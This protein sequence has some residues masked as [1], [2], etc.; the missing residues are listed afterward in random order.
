MGDLRFTINGKVVRTTIEEAFRRRKLGLDDHEIASLKSWMEEKPLAQ[1][2]IALSEE[3]C[4]SWSAD[5]LIRPNDERLLR[6]PVR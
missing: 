5:S 2:I 3:L 4:H 6:P 1:A